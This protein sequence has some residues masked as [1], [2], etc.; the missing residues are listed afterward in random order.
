MPGWMDGCKDGL[1]DEWMYVC[2][3]GCISGWVDLREGGW[4]NGLIDV[5]MNVSMC[6]FRWIFEDNALRLKLCCYKANC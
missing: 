4:I 6:K 2:V 1:L 5:Q 3:D